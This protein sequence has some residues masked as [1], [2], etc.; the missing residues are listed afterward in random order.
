MFHLN[1]KMEH[2][3]HTIICNFNSY[4]IFELNGIKILILDFG[5][6]MHRYYA[7]CSM[8]NSYPIICNMLK[9]KFCI[10]CVDTIGIYI[11][12]KNY[13][14]YELPPKCK[15]LDIK[16]ITPDLVDEMRKIHIF[17]YIIGATFNEKK[18]IVDE[19]FPKKLIPFG[20][21]RFSNKCK[22]LND[23][24]E[25]KWFREINI[26]NF[27]YNNMKSITNEIF[28]LLADNIV[29]VV[30]KNQLQILNTISVNIHT[31][32]N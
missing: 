25:N 9:P 13:I 32:L 5:F 2:P 30:D 1:H 29:S 16:D 26:K 8:I 22:Y 7:L 31:L 11:N 27:I 3:I 28:I 14:G 18:I 10:N 21:V 19:S 24:V 6:N 15:L 23:T 20:E 17:R 4:N 12:G